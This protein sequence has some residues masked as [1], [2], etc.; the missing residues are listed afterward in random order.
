IF[1][2]TRCLCRPPTSQGWYHSHMRA[3][4]RTR[5]ALPIVASEDVCNVPCFKADLV[6][7]LRAKLPDDEALEEARI[8]F[9][10]LA[11]RMRLKILYALKDGEELCVCDVAHVLSTNISVA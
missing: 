7:G 2:L 1:R 4:D 9:G 11:D 5:R 3:N 10:A 6:A 8:V